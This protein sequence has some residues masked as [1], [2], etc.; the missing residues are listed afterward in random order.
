L[1]RQEETNLLLSGRRPKLLQE[2][3]IKLERE[4]A[5]QKSITEQK[6]QKF[7]KM[8]KDKVEAAKKKELKMQGLD[9]MSDL[10][11]SP[12]SNRVNAVPAYL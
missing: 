2:D 11:E 12:T 10:S 7:M 8:M 9:E 1:E 6:K 3:K 4:K 5:Y